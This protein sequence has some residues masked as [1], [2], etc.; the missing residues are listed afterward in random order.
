MPNI[1]NIGGTLQIRQFFDIQLVH[2][3]V[4]TIVAMGNPL[5]GGFCD[6]S[7]F[8]YFHPPFLGEDSNSDYD[9]FNRGWTWNHQL[10]NIS[11]ASTTAKERRSAK[12]TVVRIPTCGDFCCRIGPCPYKFTS[13]CDHHPSRDGLIELPIPLCGGQL[14]CEKS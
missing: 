9:I 5:G 12:P 6:V 11:M 8:V 4:Q 7:I 1:G 3:A 2:L 14:L 10:G 13:S